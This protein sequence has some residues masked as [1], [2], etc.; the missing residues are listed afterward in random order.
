LGARVAKQRGASPVVD[1]RKLNEPAR[2][3]KVPGGLVEEPVRGSSC[4]NQ[5]ARDG[6]GCVDKPT[7]AGAWFRHGEQLFADRH[8][9]YEAQGVPIA[10]E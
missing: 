4:G 5:P 3:R 6:D 2:C 1:L 10:R 9:R 7:Y 8:R